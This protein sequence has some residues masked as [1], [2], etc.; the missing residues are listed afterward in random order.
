MFFSEKLGTYQAGTFWQEFVIIGFISTLRGHSNNTV[1]V[2]DCGLHSQTNQ[3]NF[4]AWSIGKLDYS[5]V[6]I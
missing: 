6:E 4:F 2:K 1:C 3:Y 5:H